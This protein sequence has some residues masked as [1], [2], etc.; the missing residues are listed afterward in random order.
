M[1]DIEE[2]KEDVETKCWSQI[3]QFM[4]KWIEISSGSS[5]DQSNKQRNYAARF[6]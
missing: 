2:T 4:E 3:R 5:K 6:L 1:N